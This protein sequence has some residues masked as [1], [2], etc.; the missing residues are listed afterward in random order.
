MSD[1]ESINV[2]NSLVPPRLSIEEQLSKLSS[3]DQKTEGNDS[4][5]SEKK[6]LMQWMML[7]EVV[8]FLMVVK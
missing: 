2:L 6:D 8:H 1:Q 3:S 7:Q 4:P 5:V